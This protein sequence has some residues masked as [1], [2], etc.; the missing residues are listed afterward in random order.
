MMKPLAIVLMVFFCQNVFLS[1]IMNKVI[2]YN[3]CKIADHV[4]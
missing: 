1:F 4:S 3:P 2:H